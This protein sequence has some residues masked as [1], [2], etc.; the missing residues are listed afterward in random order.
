MGDRDYDVTEPQVGLAVDG[1]IG[2]EQRDQRQALQ[3]DVYPS[4]RRKV[5]FG[6]R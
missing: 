2:T 6:S 4:V 1:C 5:V 3:A